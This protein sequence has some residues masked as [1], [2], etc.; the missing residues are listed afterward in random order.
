MS[1]R[2]NLFIFILTLGVFGILN[3][4]MGVVGILPQIAERFHVS[5]SQAGLLVSLFALAVA[6]SGPILPLLFSGIN[7][8]KVLLF[9]LG[10]FVLSNIVSI[11][12]PNFTIALIARVIPAF[13][14]PVYISIALTAA[15]SSVSEKEVPKAVS[16]VILGVSAGIVIGVP[17]TTFIASATSLDLAMTFFAVVNAIA[18]MGVLLFVPSMPVKERLSYGAQLSVLKK[19][20]IWQSITAVVFINAAT[21]GV[22]SYFAEYL[23]TI[24]H[25]SG[26]ALSLMLVIFGVASLFGNVLGGKLLS[27]NAIKSVVIYPFVFGAVYILLFLMGKFTAPMIIIVVLWGILYAISNN[28]SQYW[29][30]SA[31][32]E[33]PEFANGLFLTAGNLG[34]TIGTTVGGLFISGMGTQYIVLGGLLFLILSLIFILL[35]TFMYSPNKQ[36]A[37]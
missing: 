21:A 30:T 37:K 27:K 32:P 25:I 33:A 23:E 22:Y 29:I 13:L 34:I 18:F 9:V 6:I 19:P 28:I 15:A 35:R 26:T 36:L 17:I 10:V 8:R 4:E 14:H 5:V 7:R 12:A 16:K 3:T 20:I 11:F 2:N 24:T 1:K 31:A